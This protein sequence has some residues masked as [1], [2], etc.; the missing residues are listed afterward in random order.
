MP[1]KRYWKIAGYDGA[2]Q[3]FEKLLPVGSLSESEIITLLQRLAAKHL[4]EDE[5]VSSSL[6]RNASGYRSLLEPQHDRGKH[7][8]ISVHAARAYF[9]S[10]LD[11]DELPDHKE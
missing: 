8:T 5:I 3:T 9:A 7:R 11:V 10:I 6:R 1:S 4:D 2:E